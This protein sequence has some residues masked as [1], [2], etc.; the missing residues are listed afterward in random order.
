M[1][2]IAF[3]S[4]R[5]GSDQIYAINPDGTD[6]RVLSD[7]SGQAMFP[8]WSL[9]GDYL[10]Y[11]IDRDGG[12]RIF[13][14][15]LD[16]PNSPLLCC[17]FAVKDSTFSWSP[18][19]SALLYH[20]ALEPS[21][22]NNIYIEG[23]NHFAPTPITSNAGRNES[24]AWSPDGRQIAFQTDRDGNWEIYLMNVDG[25]GP[26]NLTRNGSADRL[27]NWSP[28]GRMIAFTSDR[29]GNDEIYVMN[30]DGG[31]VKRLTTD[32]AQDSYPSWSPDGKEIAFQSTR[33]GNMDI[34]VMNSDGSNVHNVTNNAA[35]DAAPSWGRD[36]RIYLQWVQELV[37]AAKADDTNSLTKLLNEPFDINAREGTVLHEAVLSGQTRIVELLLKKGANPNLPAVT[38]MESIENRHR[39]IAFLLLRSGADPNLYLPLYWAAAEGDLEIMRALLEKGADVNQNGYVGGGTALIGAIENDRPDAVE[40]LLDHKADPSIGAKFHGYPFEIAREA[41]NEKVL[42]LLRKYKGNCIDEPQRCN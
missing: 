17:A 4:N 5:S 37:R 1:G 40:L 16:N 34:F 12:T 24:P 23:P 36:G 13:R 31:D 11:N 35:D 33:S 18:D 25:S 32:T 41:K 7:K 6:L 38:L 30:R 8:K 26:V 9:N 3:H 21:R 29:D 19:G 14:F 22:Q 20:G 2:V 27:P 42:N 39:D 28:D 10:A 15:D